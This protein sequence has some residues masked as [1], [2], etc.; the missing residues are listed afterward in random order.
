MQDL[1]IFVLSKILIY[2]FHYNYNE[3]KYHCGAKLLVTNTDGLVYK[4][5]ADDLYEK[6]Y[7]DKD[8]LDFQRLS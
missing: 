3:V 6:F 2:D 1:S 5:E 8:L 4:I 7:R